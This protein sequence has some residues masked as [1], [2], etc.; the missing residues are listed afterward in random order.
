[1][2]YG[3]LFLAL[4]MYL[5]LRHENKKHLSSVFF[6]GVSLGF[7]ALFKH[8]IGA[9]ALAGSLAL[10][11]FESLRLRRYRRAWQ[12]SQDDTQDDTEHREVVEPKLRYR[13]LSMLLAGF[14]AVVLPVLVYM[15]M[16]LALQPMIKTMLFGSGEFLLSRLAVPLSPVAPLVLLATLGGAAYAS[17]RLGS[18]ALLGVGLWVTLLA[19]IAGFL[20]F[21]SEADVNQIIFYF[22]MLVLGLGFLLG[23]AGGPVV[24]GRRHTLLIVVIFAASALMEVFPRFAREQSIAAM[25]FILL[26]LFY[27]LYVLSPVIGTFVGSKWQHRFALAALPLAFTVIEARLFFNTY[28][29]DSFRFRAATSISTDRGR[30]TYFP[31]STAAMINHGGQIYSGASGYRGK[32]ICSV[33]CGNVAAVPRESKERIECSILDRCRRNSSRAC[34]NACTN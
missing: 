17:K 19:A 25:P 33:G 27:L 32:C 34:G 29:E 21:G 5:L 15:Q 22:P 23:I 7:V 20:L 28:F 16:N 31:A 1:M 26:V 30:G 8:N 11:I 13:R 6:A 9:Y 10:F 4:A 2:H 3:A 12:K 14:A 18:R 24:Y